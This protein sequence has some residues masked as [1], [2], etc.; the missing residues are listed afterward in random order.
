MAHEIGVA[1]NACGWVATEHAKAIA[2]N[3]HTYLAGVTSRTRASAERLLRE[4][5]LDCPI[6]PDYEALLSDPRVDAVAITTPNHL[7]AA[8]ALDAARA[9]KHI[10]LEKPPAITHEECDALEAA[11]RAA[12]VTTIVS[13]VL[14]WNPLVINLRRLLDCGALGEVHF[15][16]TDYWH[17]VGEIISPRRWL[18]KREFTG[19]AMLAGGSHA[20]DMIRYLVSSE[21]TRVAAFSRPPALEGFD[22]DTSE[23]GLLYF[24]NGA[25]GRVSAC[26]EAVGPYQFNI[27]L[28]GT[29]GMARDN[30]VWSRKLTPEQ[31]DFYELP[32]ILPNSGDVS[33]HPF[34]AEIDHF[35]DCVLSGAP[36][37]PDILD[38]LKTTRVCLALDEAART[39]QVVQLRT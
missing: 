12:G 7:H 34:Q 38:A 3:P 17:G 31:S 9:G 8:N 15:A 28:L 2:R 25:L 26:F 32:C 18:A 5:G 39:Q 14:R 19:S 13:F 29:E 6:Y 33:H 22:Y 24:A 11:V 27:E 16:Q 20:V 37:Q 30:R 10:I 4:L 36:C 35:A 21:V 23:S 1:I